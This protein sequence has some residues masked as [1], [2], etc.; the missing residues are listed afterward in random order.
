MRWFTLLLIVVG[1]SDSENNPKEFNNPPTIQ[2]QSH[3]DGAIFA[4]GYSTQIYAQVS[5]LNHDIE[6]LSVSWYVD[7]ELVCDWSSPEPSAVSRCDMTLFP[8]NTRV[9]VQVNDPSGE[10]ARDEI[11]VVVEPTETPVIELLSPTLTGSYYSDQLIEF[12][13]RISDA[14]DDVEALLATWE[15]SLDGPLSLD[16][17]PDSNGKIEA[18]GYLTQGQHAIQLRVEDGSGKSSVESVVIDVGGANGIPSCEIVQPLSGAAAVEGES[19]VFQALVSDP[20]VSADSL[21][22]TWNSDKDGSLGT[23]TPTSSGEVIFSYDGLSINSH[24]ISLV[25]LDEVGASCSDAILFSIGTPPSIVLNSPSD[26]QVFDVGEGVLFSA[27]VSD[28]EDLPSDLAIE[29]TSDIDGIISTQGATSSGNVQFSKTDLS[30]GLHSVLVSVVDSTGLS[31]DSIVSFRVN[32]PPTSPVLQISPDPA[33]TDDS[34]VVIASGSSDADGNSVSYSYQWYENGVLTTNTTAAVAPSDT[35]KGELWTVRVTPNDGYSDG[36]YTEESIIISNSVPI[37]STI[38]VSPA[39]PSI[40]DLLVCTASVS[41]ADGETLVEAYSWTNVTTGDSLGS[42]ASLQLNSSIINAGDVIQCGLSVS[43]SDGVGATATASVSVQNTA[44]SITAVS[45]TPSTVIYNSLLVCSVTA[46]DADGD[47][48]TESFSWTNVTTGVFLG[49]DSFLQLD[50]SLAQTGDEIQCQVTVTDPYGD[51]DT[52]TVMVSVENTWPTVSS[53]E[54]TPSSSIYVDSFLT[55]SAL[56]SDPEDG[57]LVPS[58]LWTNQTTGQSIGS[59]S[60]LQLDSSIASPQD[61]ILCEASASDSSGASV[62]DFVS[63]SIDSSVPI[64]SG[65]AMSSNFYNDSDVSCLISISDIEDGT[66]TPT[67]EWTNQ[68]TGQSLGSGQM[69]GT[70]SLLRLNSSLASPSDVIECHGTA[71]DS[72]QNSVSASLTETVDNRIPYLSAPIINPDPAYAGDTLTCI[73]NPGDEDGDTTNL[74]FEWTIDGVVQS[75]TT[76]TLTAGFIRDQVVNCTVTATDPWG[77]SASAG[78]QL[79]ISNSAPSLPSSVSIAPTSPFDTDDF[80]CSASGSTDADGDSVSYVYTW[81]VDGVT[82]GGS[83]FNGGAGIF[84]AD[85]SAGE[86]WTCSVVA[87]DGTDESSANT[88]SALISSSASEQE[89][90]FTGSPEIF[91]VPNGVYTIRIDAYGASGGD[92]VQGIGGDGG[93]AF[94]WDIPV[95]P[96]DQYEIRVGGMGESGNGAAGGY[97]GGGTGAFGSSTSYGGGGGGGASD[98][99]TVGGDLSS[100]LLVAGGGGG[101]GADGCSAGGLTG[102]SGGGTSAGAGES[103]SLCTCNPSGTGGDQSSGGTVGSWACG[104]NCN[105]TAGSFGL[106]GDGN[107]S[108]SCGG[109]TGGGGGG[110]GWYGGGGGG[111]GAGGGGSSYVS[112]STNYGHSP[113]ANVGDGSILIS[114]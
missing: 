29:W 66:L 59:G 89:F 28:N 80:E 49:Q 57:I 87:D 74:T 102:G 62:T 77:A 76:S 68:T 46:S 55:C 30:A 25:V 106:G 104:S 8:E 47:S 63:V 26:G 45:I 94:A 44:P 10:A 21:S 113:G 85:T 65:T 75:T 22:V 33:D 24:T 53:L 3:S 2:I 111:L 91:T 82:W 56:I 70:G 17:T 50:T 18:F 108:S 34:L 48:L 88:S 11:S 86:N 97:N 58:Y 15:S 6:E 69:Q 95:Q 52:S 19:V 92:G 43:D 101:G 39:S 14:E 64:V 96:G 110:A 42:G 114:W 5:D 109:T 27:E 20:D 1:C 4:E 107:T 84:S 67:Y 36:A 40:N 79:T 38:S 41:D 81:E 54:I 99:R 31:A 73:S 32:T 60:G 13:A 100:R 90:T 37:I 12:S 98:V 35:A 103:G 7:E 23:A 51:A 61:V 9:S 93:H 83:T 105:A 112:W 71:T 78:E 16:T 72:D